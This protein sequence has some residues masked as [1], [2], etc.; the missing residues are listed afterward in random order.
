MF[1]VSPLPTSAFGIEEGSGEHFNILQMEK[2]LTNTVIQISNL[3]S[4][5]TF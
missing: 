2:P 5:P 4:F 3:Y 1:T